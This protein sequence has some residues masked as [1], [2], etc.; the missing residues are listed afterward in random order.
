MDTYEKIHLLNKMLNDLFRGSEGHEVV[1]LLCQVLRE[2]E[3]K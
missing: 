2:L 3:A 1:E